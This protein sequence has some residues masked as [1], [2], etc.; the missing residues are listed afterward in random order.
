MLFDEKKL[1]E[2]TTEEIKRNVLKRRIE[3]LEDLFISLE[4]HYRGAI[5]VEDKSRTL[6][7]MKALEYVIMKLT[8]ELNE[9]QRM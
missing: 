8:G 6:K 1:E 7:R 4:N 5:E 9:M 3:I 2:M